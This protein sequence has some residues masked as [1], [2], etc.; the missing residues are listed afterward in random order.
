M[1]QPW[2]VTR[3]ATARLGKRAAAAVAVAVAEGSRPKVDGISRR[4]RRQR[5]ETRGGAGR[6]GFA[7][8]W[9]VNG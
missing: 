8:T 7:A 6:A 9:L 2:R 3:S 5:T 1:W 4:G